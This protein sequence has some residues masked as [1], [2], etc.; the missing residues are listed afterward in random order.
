LA[1]EEIK[2]VEGEKVSERGNFPVIE[3]KIPHIKSLQKNWIGLSQGTLIDFWSIDK[4]EKITVFT[5]RPDTIYGVAAIALS[6]NHP[7]IREITLP[8]YKQKVTDFCE[9]WKDKKESKEIAGEFTEDP[10]SRSRPDYPSEVSPLFTKQESKQ[11]WEVDFAFAKKYCLPTKGLIFIHF[12]MYAMWMD[13]SC[14]PPPGVYTNSPLI[15]GL[16]NK[17]K[18]IILINRE[19]KKKQVENT[20]QT[21]LSE[22]ELPLELPPLKDFA[23]NPNYYAP[24]QKVEN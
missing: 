15:D 2:N 14:G 23:P 17:E 22:N 13:G 7:L 19:L 4:S 1:N 24:L 5:T 11:N 6:I 21:L 10:N 8:E 3:K 18:A 20:T 9:Y 16:K 12:G